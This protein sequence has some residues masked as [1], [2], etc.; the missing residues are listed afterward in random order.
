M[1]HEGDPINIPRSI[2][3]TILPGGNDHVF[4]YCG[5]E[6]EAIKNKQVYQTSYNE[7]NGLGNVIRQKQSE[8]EKRKI[9]RTQLVVLVKP[10][11]GSS[12]KNIVNILDEM[13][14]NAVTRYTIVDPERE[15]A[16]FLGKLN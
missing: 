3:L 7:I 4:Y 2:S 15:E 16:I 10:G 13:L 1:P 8:L 14:I 11:N 6:E 12:Y 5:T 9:D